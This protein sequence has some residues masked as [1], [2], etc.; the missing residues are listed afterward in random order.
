M[1]H[2][3][4]ARPPTIGTSTAPDL[5]VLALSSDAGLGGYGCAHSLKSRRQARQ[6]MRHRVVAWR[7]KARLETQ[8][9][10]MRMVAS[11]EKNAHVDGELRGKESRG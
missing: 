8:A 6:L 1:V 10:M 4:S 2:T 9:R 11:L 5:P 7:Q 3:A